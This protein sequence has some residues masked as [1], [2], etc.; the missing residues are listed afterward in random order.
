MQTELSRRELAPCT[1]SPPSMH[2][3]SLRAG[4][5]RASAGCRSCAHNE[6][7]RAWNTHAMNMYAH[8]KGFVDVD[9]GNV[10]AAGNL[11]AC[12]QFR[13]MD[14]GKS[15]VATVLHGAIAMEACRTPC[16]SVGRKS[17][18]SRSLLAGQG[19]R[20]C[21]WPSPCLLRSCHLRPTRNFGGIWTPPLGTPSEARCTV[22]SSL[23]GKPRRFEWCTEPAGLRSGQCAMSH[24]RRSFHRA[25]PLVPNSGLSD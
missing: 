23:I 21:H 13:Y 25:F 20:T 14:M 5:S 11:R 6:H 2:K 24:T 8:A 9:F 16:H 12:G 19:Y 10:N 17:F 7:A 18:S 1:Q 3:Q 4:M 22:C 15:G